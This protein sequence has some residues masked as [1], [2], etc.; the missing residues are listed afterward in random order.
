MKTFAFSNPLDPTAMM[1]GVEN[2]SEG[3][4]VDP[5]ELLLSEVRRL[6]GDERAN[7]SAK[8]LE[9]FE[10]ALLRLVAENP[11]VY[12][13]AEDPASQRQVVAELIG[14]LKPSFLTR[15]IAELRR[16]AG[17]ISVCGLWIHRAVFTFVAFGLLA[18]LILPI[19]A[20]SLMSSTAWGWLPGVIGVVAALAI[21]SWILS[22][23]RNS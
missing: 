10:L 20:V 13:A 2:K 21:G 19:C 4:R 12:G 18:A 7:M 8:I 22:R 6:G 15:T 14:F 23:I 9:M 5:D 16:K 3:R 17:Y 11:K 1:W